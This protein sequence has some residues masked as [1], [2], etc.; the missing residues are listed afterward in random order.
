[1]SSYA[2]KLLFGDQPIPIVI[3]GRYINATRMSRWLQLFNR[4][5]RAKYILVVI[6]YYSKKVFARALNDATS[7]TIVQAL[8]A[9]CQNDAQNTYPHILQ[10][11]S[12]PNFTSPQIENFCQQHNIEDIRVKTYTPNSNGLVERAIQTLRNKIKASF[13]LHNDFEWVAFLPACLQN[14]NGQRHTSTRYTPTELWTAGYNPPPA[15]AIDF[16]LKPSDTNTID[17]IRLAVQGKLLKRANDMIRRTDRRGRNLLPDVFALNQLV[18]VKIASIQ[19]KMRKRLKENIQKKLT[20]ITYT[21]RLFRINSIIVP[22]QASNFNAG[23]AVNPVWNVVNQRYTIRDALNGGILGNPDGTAK[24]FF[25]SDLI[26]V[27]EPNIN[28]NVQ[29]EARANQINR[30]D[31]YQG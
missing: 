10:T 2:I 12:A 3:N 13:V 8:Q 9:I 1:M 5:G 4:Q 29:T 16:Q 11:D 17:E 19:K 7:N 20:A 30:F 25:G 24:Q 26:K 31:A 28:P 27:G 18:R 21:P 23:Q 6:D 14:I 15:Q 22:P